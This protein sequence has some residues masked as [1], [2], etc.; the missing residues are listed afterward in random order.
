VKSF[1]PQDVVGA[2][3]EQLDHRFDRLDASIKE[4]IMMDM[5]IE[6]EALA[7]YLNTCRLDKWYQGALDLAKKDV[8][9]DVDEETNDGKKMQDIAQKL[10]DMEMEIAKNEKSKA[11]ALLKSKPRFKVRRGGSAGNLRRSIQ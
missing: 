5:R 4:R 10:H 6:D 8:E 7:P 2:C 3:T 1:S 9:K 11:Q